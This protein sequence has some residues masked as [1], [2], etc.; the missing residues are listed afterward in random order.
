MEE[1]FREKKNNRIILWERVL[2]NIKLMDE[3]FPFSRDDI[4]RK[5]SNF[6]VTYNRIK[7]RSK[8][9]GEISTTWEFYDKLDE[10]YG[11][12]NDIEITECNLDTTCSYFTE[13]F[14]K[15]C[16]SQIKPNHHKDSSPPPEKRNRIDIMELL[17]KE[18]QAD[19]KLLQDLLSCEK[20]KLRVEKKKIEEIKKLREAVLKI[21][22]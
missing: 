18:G 5:Y 6:M 8:T 14:G 19:R 4:Y 2:R 16:M 3:T 22:K 17:S 10:I 12:R 9:S 20:E 15:P 13:D 1:E 7:K 21:R 11:C